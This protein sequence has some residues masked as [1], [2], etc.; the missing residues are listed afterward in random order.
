MKTLV[1]LGL[2]IF[3][4]IS[5]LPLAT[6]ASDNKRL[7]IF[8][9]RG[10]DFTLYDSQNTPIHLRDFQGKVVLLNFGY[11]SCPDVCPLILSHLKQAYKRLG[12]NTENVQTVFVTLDPE[13]DTPK[14]LRDYV[15]YFHPSFL[16]LSGSPTDIQT[17]AKQYRVRYF[18]ETLASAKGYFVAHTDYVYLIDQQG[19]YRGKYKTRW[20]LNDLIEDIQTLLAHP[21]S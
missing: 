18:K 5:T 12:S 20:G 11:T 17:V 7:K 4:A 8:E 16:A 9:D 1:I 15:T 13:R 10:G 6:H 2:F 19:R 14:H 3:G 21:Q